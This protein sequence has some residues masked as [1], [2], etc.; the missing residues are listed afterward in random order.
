MKRNEKIDYSNTDIKLKSVEPLS[1]HN[2][3]IYEV[4][5][6]MLKNSITTMR[7]FCNFMITISIGAIPIYLG[8]LEYILPENVGLPVSKLVLSFIPPFLFL[9]SALIFILGYFPQVD[10]FS[11]DIIEEVKKAHET[12]ILKRKKFINCGVIIFLTGTV[13]AILSLLMHIIER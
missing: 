12:T 3:A 13:F 1:P 7:D 4:G 6:D 5:K 2:E 11:L 10:Y 9:V 8:L